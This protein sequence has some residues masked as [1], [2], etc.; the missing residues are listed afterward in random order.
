MA[1]AKQRVSEVK[2]YFERALNDDQVRENIRNAFF[3]ARDVYDELLG[4]RGASAMASRIAT[5]EEIR[6]N[7]RRAVDEL[8][9]AADRVRGRDEHTARN[10]LLLLTGVVIGVL[11]NPF[12]GPSA[13]KWLKATVFGG[14][15]EPAYE[16]DGQP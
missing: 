15:E 4:G 14:G 12:T 1:S 13:R 2:P 9:T 7:L 11:F 6:D 10:V 16:S 8:R 5:D 3:A